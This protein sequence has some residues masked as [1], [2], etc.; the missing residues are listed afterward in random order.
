M[1][2]QAYQQVKPVKAAAESN[3]RR[4]NIRRR[5]KQEPEVK[6]AECG[7]CGSEIPA[8]ATECSTCGAKFE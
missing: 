7:A 8:D 1:T 5:T 6:M 4:R 2:T 3:K